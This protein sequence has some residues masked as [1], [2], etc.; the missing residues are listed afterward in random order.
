MRRLG[1]IQNNF[2]T[3]VLLRHFFGWRGSEAYS[4][5]L[6]FAVLLFSNFSLA[7]DRENQVPNYNFLFHEDLPTVSASLIPPSVNSEDLTIAIATDSQGNVYTLSF[8]K[9]VD[10]RDPDG[11]LLN[12]NFINGLK[13]PMDIAIDSDGFIYIADYEASGDDFNDDGQIKIYD[14]QGN[15]VRSILTSYFR[16][17]GI[18]VNENYV[19]IAEYND[20][21]QG[22][23]STPSSRVRIVDKIT[24][25][26]VAVNN[27]ISIPYRIA[28]N[29]LG[30]V[31]VSKAGNG[32]A[33]LFLS[34]D[35]SIQGQLPNIQSPGSVEVDVFDYIHVIEYSGRINFSE[36]INFA[37][38]DFGDIQDIAEEIDKG[39]DA[40]SFGIKV[41]DPSQTFR[42]FL[43]ERIDFPVDLAFNSCDRMYVNNGD[44]FGGNVIFV[45]YVPSRL[46]F[47]LEIYKRTPSADVTP[48]IASCGSNFAIELSAGGTGNITWE[49]LNDG[50]F[51]LCGNVTYELSKSS[52]TEADEGPNVITLTVKDEQGYTSSCN[53]TIQVNIEEATDDE[54]PIFTSCEDQTFTASANQCGA[55]VNFDIPTATD[56]SGNVSITQVS[57]PAPGDFFPVGTSIVKFTATDP[58]NN[59]VDCSIEIIVIDAEDPVFTNC[60]ADKTVQLS[61]GETSMVVN[62]PTPVA[63]DNCGGFSVSQTGG[64]LSGTQF[65]EGTHPI[66]FTVTDA[67]GRT[68]VCQFNVVVSPPV[69][70]LPP[71]FTNCPSIINLDSDPGTCGAVAT[72]P[73]LEAEDNEND[74]VTITRIDNGPSSGRMYFLL[75]LQR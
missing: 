14:P 60:P 52:F 10:K 18:D 47:D 16:P 21:E 74:D 40:E 12:G 53:V 24:G 67:A 8:G 54:D 72:F 57:G 71:T 39:I 65:T 55:V 22:P 20:G 58:S 26:A 30:E 51:D 27:N 59:S 73:G 36:F 66:E 34:S 43:K 41:Y 45:G 62:F 25:T 23:E 4:R 70:N 48:P 2:S 38:M 56:N 46:E 68:K 63:D 13:S 17:L 6:V 35:L 75:E 9:G 61:T 42:Y 49:D 69:E 29:S 32:S 1:S 33:V 50:S 3:A 15:Y 64:Q 5:I 37:T 7:Q 19:Y 11:N 28:V 31:F 44:M